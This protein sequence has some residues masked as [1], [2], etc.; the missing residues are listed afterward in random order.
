MIKE[1]IHGASINL[2]NNFND[3]PAI[4]GAEESTTVWNQFHKSETTNFEIF[5]CNRRTNTLD[6]FL[7]F[8]FNNQFHK[9]E[10][11]NFEEFKCNRRTKTLNYFL[12][13]SS[14][15]NFTNHKPRIS[16][17]S[18]A[19]EEQINLPW[20][21]SG[22]YSTSDKSTSSAG[23]ITSFFPILHRKS[24]EDSNY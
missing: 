1:P 9:S 16:K 2:T 21:T 20:I 19:I 15:I 12:F 8:F 4:W 24:K 23:T 11:T 10:T 14:T 5:K 6:Y 3:N 7:S 22:L 13:F 18:N 17:K